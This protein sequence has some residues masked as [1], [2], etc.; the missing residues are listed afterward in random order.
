MGGTALLIHGALAPDRLAA[1][2]VPRTFLDRLLGRTRESQP[3]WRPGGRGRE[4]IE[5]DSSELQPLITR[6]RAFLSRRLPE[7]NAASVDTLQYLEIR[8]IPSLYLR[9]E[10]EIGQ[11]PAWY[12]QIGFSGCAGMAEVSA[13]VACHWAAAWAREEMPA[14]ESEVFQPFGFAPTPGQQLG[15][16]EA[17]LPV[18]ELGYLRYLPAED[19]E[20]DGLVFEVDYAVVEGRD[21]TEQRVADASARHGAMMADGKCR[22]Q[23][24]APGQA[25]LS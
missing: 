18:A 24:C 23:L 14:L 20:E 13:A 22:C 2:P 10:R 11:E 16:D 12:T 4:R 6:F 25:V 5:V 19:R 1:R 21:D 7:P 8:D 17:F 9:G 15:W 3:R